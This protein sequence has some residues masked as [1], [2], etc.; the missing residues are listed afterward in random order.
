MLETLILVLAV[1]AVLGG[2]SGAG[3]FLHQYISSKRYQ[4]AK[5]EASRI[6]EDAD[7]QKKGIVL[8]AKE[9]AFKIRSSGEAD[10]KER[11]SEL[12]RLEHRLAN[13]EEQQERRSENLE[14][15][16]RS[17][18]AK[19]K[20]AEGLHTEF[21]QM[22]A[23]EMQLLEQISGMSAND[24]KDLLIRR[25]EEEIQHE[26]ARRYRDFEEQAKAEAD[27]KARKIIALAIHRLA[28]DVVSES[29]VTVVPI[30]SDDMKGRIIGRE[31]RNIR[32][33]EAATGVDLIVDDTPEAV[34]IS[35]FDPIRREIA[36]VA[37]NKLILDGRIHPA[38]IEEM[39]EKATKEVEE[40]IWKEGE[41]AVFEVGVRGLNPEVIKLLG[42]LK[43]RYSYGENVLQHSM[44]VSLLAGMLAA[45]A[46]ANTDV[47][48]A[49][50]LLHDIGKALTHEVEGPHA[51]IGA[52]IAEKYGVPPA[53]LSAIME[54]H[55]TE[56]SSVE[57]F[58]VSAAD[59]IS[60]ARPGARRDSL[61]QYV[62]RLEALESVANSFDGVERCFAIQAGREVRILVK[63]D[64]VDDVAASKMARDI[65][66]K[67]EDSLTYPGQIK[68]TVIRETRVTEYAR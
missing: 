49:G 2:G 31:G 6:L 20:E 10:L 43:Y 51:E 60:A 7:K 26:V 48:K 27:E 58:L 14:R 8:E 36:R 5:T 16:E 40:T 52:D 23:K 22:K 66:K 3:Y 29:T 54:H 12:N 19:E 30:P 64:N 4:A 50:G 46:G 56:M 42:R 24:A 9:E 33:I 67:I 13:R 37:L 18:S 34:T 44:E 38:R 25:A 32:A 45:E 63:P 41:R 28:V 11:R 55:D 62:K 21:E 47:A 59:A 53:I 1:L 15:R 17:L 68:V 35:C 57:A 61:E 39:V 65:V